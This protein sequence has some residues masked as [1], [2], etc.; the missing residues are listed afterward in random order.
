[1]E[2]IDIDL[3]REERGEEQKKEKKGNEFH[4][5]LHLYFCIR[6]SYSP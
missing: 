5:F 2:F 4:L 1:M 3:P 6:P